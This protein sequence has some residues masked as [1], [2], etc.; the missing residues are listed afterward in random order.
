MSSPADV[1]APIAYLADGDGPVEHRVYPVSSG[2]PSTR[3]PIAFVTMPVHDARPLADALDIDVQGFVPC[4]FPPV[5][6]D[7][8]DD[9]YVREHYYPQV[10]EFVRARLAARAVFVFDHN[11]R[12]RVRAGRGETGVRV[13]VEA[14]HNDYT[15]NSGPRRARE[16]L[17]DHGREDL[18]GRRCAL[19]NL[20]RPLI[21][22]VQDLPLALCD[23]RTV[24]ADDIVDT[25]IHHY[26]ERDLERP[27]HT[28]EIQSLRHAAAHRWYWFPDMQ[29]S[30]AL[31]LKCYDSATDGRARFMPHTAFTHPSPPP[32][33]TPRESIEARTLVV[34]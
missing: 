27:G 15:V 23:A 14:A 30:E 25:P 5:D 6:G 11:V 9:R 28:G 2:R 33:C 3:P 26:V 8:C 12:S 19:V 18:A 21:G 10:A 31:L 22:P 17:A 7:C 34:F 32:G 29:P 24:G 4:A 13:P 20:W 1:R 16:V